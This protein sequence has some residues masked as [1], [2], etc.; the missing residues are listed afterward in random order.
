M[1]PS[2]NPVCSCIESKGAHVQTPLIHST[3]ILRAPDTELGVRDMKITL[4]GPQA[5][6]GRKSNKNILE[7]TAFW[8]RKVME[9]N[10]ECQLPHT[11]VREGLKHQ[12]RLSQVS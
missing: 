11:W 9:R 6:G 10:Q 8:G 3:Y 5:Q 7:M 4:G 1:C 12:E 2:S